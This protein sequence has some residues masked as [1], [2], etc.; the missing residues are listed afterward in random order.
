[1]TLVRARRRLLPL[2]FGV[3]CACAPALRQPPPVATLGQPLAS[4]PAAVP[5]SVDHLLS[6][7]GDQFNRRPDADAVRQAY[8]PFLAAARADDTRVEGLLGAA[9][10]AAWII[11]HDDDERRRSALATEAVQVCQWCVERAPTQVACKYRLALAL[12]QQARERRS[13]AK[14]G[15]S[16]MV[17]LLDDVIATAPEFDGAGGHRVLA[18]VLL[19][20]PGWPAGPGDPEA[21]LEH[22]R[23]ADRLAPDNPDNLL[24]LGEAL[25]KAGDPEQARAAFARAQDVARR[26]A[27]AGDP[28]APETA[29]AAARA[30]EML[31]R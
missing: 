22:A 18:L 1:M 17:A 28:D 6:E 15:L 29:G 14:D 21:A 30:L 24:V 20:A 4:E 2:G 16:T 10:S 12:G 8:K 27:D 5:A 25:A 19:R 26:R 11:E 13:T 23:Q 3:L 7:A 9:R 31:P